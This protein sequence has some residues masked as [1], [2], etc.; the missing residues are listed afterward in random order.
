MNEKL[1][2]YIADFFLYSFA[3]FIRIFYF[4]L[5]VFKFLSGCIGKQAADIGF[6]FSF[7]INHIALSLKYSGV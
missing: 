6:V 4:L 2:D 3:S 1:F 5:I 7:V